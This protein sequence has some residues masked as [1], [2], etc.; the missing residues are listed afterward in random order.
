LILV[1]KDVA[2]INTSIERFIHNVI[3]LGAQQVATTNQSFTA[4]IEQDMLSRLCD[5]CLT[6]EYNL[7]SH[8]VFSRLLI[9][10]SITK[11][12]IDSLKK[13]CVSHH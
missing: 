7:S 3:R 1:E 2:I 6:Q 11:F 10:V 8:D 9:T 5:E 12:N 13:V 4:I